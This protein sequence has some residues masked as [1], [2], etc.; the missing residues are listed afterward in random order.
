[1]NIRSRLY[2]LWKYLSEKKL[3]EHYRKHYK[4]EIEYFESYKDKKPSSQMKR[5]MK[6]LQKYWGCY[7]FQYIR[8]GFYKKSCTL[9]MQEMKDYIPNYFAYYLFFPKFFKDYGIITEDKELTHRLLESYQVNQPVLLL[10]YKNGEFYGQN[11]EFID[12]LTIEKIIDS[13]T[14]EKLFLKPTQGLGGKGII[15]FNKKDRFLDKSGNQISSDYIRNNVGENEDYILQEGLK[16]HD[17]L[18][19]IYPSSINTFRVMTSLEKGKTKILFAMLRMGQGGNQLDNASQQG[20]V[21]KINIETGAFDDLGYTGLG[22]TL[23]EHPDSKFEFNGYVF[24]HWQKVRDF[25]LSTAQ[26]IDSIKYIG[27]DIAYTSDGPAVIEMNAG[28]GL[29]FLQDC[30]G[31]VREAYGIDNPRKYWYSDKYAIKDL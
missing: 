23:H 19:K 28:A 5:E 11:K 1:M 17:E 18:K 9:G 22:K 21:C 16:Q 25:V 10:Q 31:G 3:R 12:D 8:Y 30:H 29:E 2:W 14:A 24:P 4:T 15:V 20:L 7:P 13:S 6:A 27:W 26:K